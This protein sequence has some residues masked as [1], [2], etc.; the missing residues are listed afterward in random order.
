MATVV[1][2]TTT[3]TTSALEQHIQQNASLMVHFQLP[4]CK[5][6]QRIK[7][8]LCK[9]HEE[10]PKVPFY[11]AQEDEVDF[12]LARASLEMKKK[13]WNKFPYT[14]TFLNGQAHHFISG[15]TADSLLERHNVLQSL[16]PLIK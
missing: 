1:T 11:F 5:P 16:H 15:A 10:S 3:S 2:T 6:C 9:M 7:P 14:V 4:G 8:I 13:L 12:A